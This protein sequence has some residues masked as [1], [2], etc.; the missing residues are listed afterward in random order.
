VPLVSPG[1]EQWKLLTAA[2]RE[3]ARF[4]NHR[5]AERYLRAK[6]VKLEPSVFVEYRDKLSSVARLGVDTHV[7]GAWQRSGRK[8]LAGVER[9]A[10]MDS[11]RALAFQVHQ[12]GGRVDRD[13]GGFMIRV[14]VLPAATAGLEELPIYM[15]AVARDKYMGDVLDK[16]AS[17]E[18]PIK[19]IALVFKRQSAKVKAQL[20]YLRPAVVVE[21][22]SQVSVLALEADGQRLVIRCNGRELHL[23]DHL[24][25]LR[26]MKD[27]F[28]GIHDRLRMSLGKARRW[29]EMRR[30][31]VR[32]G[33]F[34]TWSV[35]PLHEL[36]ARI[37]VWCVEQDAGC[38]K[39]AIDGGDLPWHRL[40]EQC[41]YK[42]AEAGVVIVERRGDDEEGGKETPKESGGVASVKIR[43]SKSG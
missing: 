31:L 18:W 30:A 43:R 34:E 40:R 23:T 4:G 2:A 20:S 35:S 17:G 15:P 9:L 8:I 21:P 25:R 7:K 41:K 42:G 16:I 19:R 38:L 33:N 32:A 22:H 3:A 26:S 24:H 1:K 28:A 12:G 37:I 10:H 36:S 29:H 14:R 5:M 6:G 27:H 13:P 11:Y 39:W